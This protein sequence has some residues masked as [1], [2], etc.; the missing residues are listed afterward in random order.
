LISELSPYPKYKNSQAAWIGKLPAHWQVLPNRALFSEVRDRNFPSEE[1]LSVTINK[2]VIKQKALLDESSKKDS[3]NLDK[4]KYKLVRPG[5]IAYNKMRAWQGALGASEYQGIVS[6]AYVVMR[7]RKKQFLPA[8]FNHL[9]RTP[10]FAKEAERWSYGIT[11]DMWSLRPEHFRLIQTPVPPPDEQAAIVRFLDW[12]NGRIDRAIRAKKKIISLLNEQKQ[13]IIQ[14]AVTRGLNPNIKMQASGI[15]WISEAPSH[16]KWVP[17]KGHLQ[18]MDYGI[19]E[20]STEDG[21]IRVL[22]MG[23][24]QKGEV[25]LP[26]SGGVN[27]VSDDLLLEH[28]DLLFTRTNG[29]PDLV[30]KV[31][32]FR[33]L[34]S[35][36][37]TFASYLVRLRAKETTNPEWLH[38]VLTSNSFWAFAKSH[39]LV[40]LQ[41]NLNATRYS[42]FKLPTPPRN[43]QDEI[44]KAIVNATAPL[45][46]TISKL[47]K[48]IEFLHEYRT[49]LV[50]D[51]VTGK[52]DVNIAATQLAPEINP[53]ELQLDETVGAEDNEEMEMMGDKE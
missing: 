17:I 45:F 43:E 11:S 22:T 47:T 51:I 33:G 3:S 14:Q 18:K 19:S 46:S 27:L 7:L 40:N 24:I 9:F 20:V 12:A 10:Q 4:S 52:S 31:G 21:L 1:M 49:R 30:G 38:Y 48:E 15:P 34:R 44:V 5:D 39:A 8:Y 42:R 2:G 41:T 29:N 23:N 36:K 16:W 35:D 53:T 13:A 26:K 50:T 28:H 6:P 25:I 37:V 32:I